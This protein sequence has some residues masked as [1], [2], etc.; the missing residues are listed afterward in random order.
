[1]ALSGAAT[2]AAN[3]IT[4]TYN[5]NGYNATSNAGGM[6]SGGHRVNFLPALQDLV[7]YGQGIVTETNSIFGSVQG[8]ANSAAQSA[9]AAAGSVTTAAGYVSAA[10]AYA[11]NAASSATAAST[12][13]AAA[14]SY[15][16]Q[17]AAFTP[18]GYQATLDAKLAIASKATTA[19][20]QAGTEN[21][22][23]MTA[24]TT[25]DAVLAL[26]SF[27]K[28]TVFT[29]GGTFSKDPRTKRIFVECIGGGGAGA[30]STTSSPVASGGCGGSYN[31]AWVDAAS[32]G[33][34]ET[35][36]VG[37]GG[38]G[39]TQVAAA[40]FA[41][42]NQGGPSSFG[43]WLKAL[44]GSGGHNSGVTTLAVPTTV[45]GSNRTSTFGSVPGSD[46]GCG[47]F[48]PGADTLRGG[49]G[50][51]GSAG[52]AAYSGGTSFA[53]GAGSAGIT[54][55]GATA[56]PGTAP[57]GGGGAAAATSGGNVT[58]GAGARGE[59]RVWEFG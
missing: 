16:D 40:G 57:G 15:R 50:G 48:G 10:S 26:A 5:G 59:V 13:A 21:T 28:R 56:S 19:E 32:V 35:V 36:L 7:T 29:A 54:G 33:A 47:I 25:K 37:A 2:A 52:S 44:G 43:T 51:G 22:H 30:A 11:G 17:A 55:N 49:G 27:F 9:S 18:A 53:H 31:S 46:W 3:R 23:Y 41:L 6:G 14:L 1:M 24:S 38:S 20:A 12:S 34:T 4:A 39:T 45:A 58:S 8:V 42:G